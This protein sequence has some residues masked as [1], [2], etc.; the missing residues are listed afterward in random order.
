[1]LMKRPDLIPEWLRLIERKKTAISKDGKIVF[2]DI[3]L[4]M[5]MLFESKYSIMPTITK[6]NNKGWDGSG[7]NC[8]EGDYDQPDMDSSRE[9]N[10]L[11]KDIIFDVGTNS[12]ILKKY[13]CKVK[14]KRL[15]DKIYQNIFHK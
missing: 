3:A 9:W 11:E 10:P 4:T 14:I 2:C 8:C 7:L 1:M 12:R 13:F 15:K 5:Y 6:V